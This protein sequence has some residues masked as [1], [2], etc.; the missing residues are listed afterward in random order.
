MEQRLAR[1]AGE[2]FIN[3]ETFR[4]SGVGVATVVW[5]VEEGGVLYASAPRHTGKVKRL[6]NGGRVRIVP[7]DSRGTPR[8]DWIDAEAELI[9]GER[10]EHFERLLD[11]KYGLQ[12]KLLDLFGKV[13]K[14]RYSVIAVRIAAPVVAEATNAAAV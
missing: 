6:R 11:R 3:L 4:R 8:G 14:W 2:K 12:K 13:K 9:E 5:F 10:A 1:F 7:C